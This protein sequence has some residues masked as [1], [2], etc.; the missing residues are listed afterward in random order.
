MADEETTDK[1]KEYEEEHPVTPG[2]ETVKV[3]DAD[4]NVQ[5]MTKAQ[6]D[7][8]PEG[9]AELLDGDDEDEEGE[10]TE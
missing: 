9:S 7:A 2:E 6:F 5:H 10:E 3:R 1:G 8:L 4:G